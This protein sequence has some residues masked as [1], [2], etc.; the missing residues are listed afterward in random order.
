VP[1]DKKRDNTVDG[2]GRQQKEKP[3]ASKQIQINFSPK[4]AHAG[5][6]R[7]ARRDARHDFGDI[8]KFHAAFDCTGQSLTCNACNQPI[9][10]G[11]CL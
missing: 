2:E 3:G 5:M 11:S 4:A 1:M 10:T 9:I 6:V 7:D 8:A